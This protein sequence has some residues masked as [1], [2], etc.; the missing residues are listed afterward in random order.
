MSLFELPSDTKLDLKFLDSVK[1]E[2]WA[3][4]YSWSPFTVLLVKD[5]GDAERINA[6]FKTARDF[7]Y[8]DRKLTQKYCA[9]KIAQKQ[10]TPVYMPLDSAAQK[11]YRVDY[12][13]EEAEIK[14]QTAVVVPASR[15]PLAEPELWTN[16]KGEVGVRVGSDVLAASVASMTRWTGSEVA[17]SMPV[18]T[19]M[20]YQFKYARPDGIKPFLFLIPGGTEKTGM[21]G[22]VWAHYLMSVLQKMKTEDYLIF[23]TNWVRSMF[24]LDKPA[25][26]VKIPEIFEQNISMLVFQGKHYY[27]VEYQKPSALGSF[28]NAYQVSQIYEKMAQQIVE[29]AAA[30]QG[31]SSGI[32]MLS[33]SRSS[34][35][36]V[37]KTIA[38]MEQTVSLIVGMNNERVV[39]DGYATPEV[40]RIRNSV[41]RWAPSIKVFQRVPAFQISNQQLQTADVSTGLYI[42]R[43]KT[44][45]DSSLVA[46]RVGKMKSYSPQEAI[47]KMWSHVETAV[48]TGSNVVYYAAGLP[49]L[50]EKMSIKAF[51]AGGAWASVFFFSQKEVL[52][53]ALI[54]KNGLERKEY[55][56]IVPAKVH[57]AVVQGMNNT[58]ASWI[59][60][61][62]NVNFSFSALLEPMKVD[63]KVYVGFS[64]DKDEFTVDYLYDEDDDNIVDPDGIV[65][66]GGETLQRPSR[67]ARNEDQATQESEEG[68]TPA[69]DTVDEA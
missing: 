34:W 62:V 27:K 43:G 59:V 61:P 2:S 63:K 9:W 5:Q 40:E 21:K 8:D 29:F 26:N 58:V 23:M 55:Q 60:P 37:S 52:T 69:A 33:Q 28:R 35:G 56:P 68:F 44:S 6:R 38:E 12:T 4:T 57:E 42:I 17:F 47:A 41:Y 65:D 36:L 48:S 30:R 53:K 64:P 1:P 39:L 14:G 31:D 66:D 51:A 54:G 22:R 18:D 45:L 16:S 19:M 3:Q 13:Q 49:P 7:T 10:Q 11:G 15:V 50:Q 67:R 25:Q 20:K 32:S 24:D 46:T